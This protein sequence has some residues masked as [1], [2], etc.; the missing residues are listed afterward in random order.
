MKLVE[1]QWNPTNRQLRQFAVI[2]LCALPMLGWIFGA[3]LQVI[4]LLAAL[5][6]VLAVAGVAVPITVKPVFLA[7]TIVATPIGMVIGELAM[8]LI[9]FGVILPFGLFFRAIQRDALQLTLDRN[10]K[11]YWKA[12][13]QPN[14][15]ASY[16]RQS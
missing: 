12:K 1:V 4:G 15:M 5:G 2:C 14:G 10:A 6:L 8:L 7:A 3:N 16:Y 9:F 13:R 11:T